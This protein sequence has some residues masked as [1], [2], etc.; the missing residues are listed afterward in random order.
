M[1]RKPKLISSAILL[2]IAPV[3]VADHPDAINLPGLSVQGVA[4]EGTPYRLS[5]ESRPSSDTGELVRGLPGAELNRNG[6]LTGHV[7]YRGMYADRVNVLV[8]GM[9]MH[10]AGPNSMD[11]PLSYIPASDVEELTLHRGIAP[12]SSGMETIGG[13]VEATSKKTEFA[14]GDAFEFHGEANAG[15]SHNNRSFQTGIRSALVN[16]SQRLELKALRD[17]GDDSRFR[18]GEITPTEYERDQL[19]LNYAIRNDNTEANFTIKHHDTGDSGTPALPMDIL[20]A[21]GEHYTADIRHQL[22]NGG[23]LIAKLYYQDTDHRMNNFSLRTSP[24][25]PMMFR[26]TDADVEASGLSLHY[27][28][29][30]WTLGF[31]A[32]NATHNATINNPNNSGFRVTNFNDAE[33]DRYS[34]FAEWDGA[35]NNDW[36]MQ[37]GIRYSHIRMDADAVSADGL[38]GPMAAMMGANAQRFNNSN[39]AQSDNLLDLAAT[40]KRRMSSD[41]DLHLGLAQKERAA[42]YQERY[43]WFPA[44]ATSGLADGNTYLGDVGLDP[45]TAWQLEAG[46]D[47]HRPDF[48]VSPRVFYHRVDDYIQGVGTN[49]PDGRLQFANVDAELYGLDTNWFAAISDHWQLEGTISYTRGKRRDTGDN[50]YRIAPLS[51]RTLLSYRQPDWHIGIEA[52]TVAAQN[53]VAAEN[54]E[55]KTSGYAVFNLQGGKTLDKDLRIDAGVRNLF[56][57]EYST[58]LSGYNRVKGNPDIAEMDR[59]PAMGRSIYVNLNYQW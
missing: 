23:E 58:H 7:Q 27:A 53:D 57:R 1:T 24:G 42:S 32:D 47:W 46:L 3:V 15:F 6:P 25:D 54:R 12:V 29:N 26:Q 56:D 37:S 17:K 48:A 8:D 21:R 40:F 41:L 28:I 20:F 44:E 2:A 30:N 13:T 4:G 18:S 5:P 34:L 45:E 11:S 31:D 50:L 43:L 35:L 51:A 38:M 36:S 52:E 59:L 33:R 39:R 49:L 10:Q 19:S 14:T 22:T 16:D 9:K 55:Q